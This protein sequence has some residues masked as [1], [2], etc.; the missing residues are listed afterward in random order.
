MNYRQLEE[1]INKWTLELEEQEKIFLQQA[2]QVNAWDRLL[3]DN[4]EKVSGHRCIHAGV[5]RLRV[6]KTSTFA[7]PVLSLLLTIA[8]LLAISVQSFCQVYE[9]CKCKITLLFIARL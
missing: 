2:T 8:A 6:D 4:G 9:H 3:I 5:I 1:S 7:C